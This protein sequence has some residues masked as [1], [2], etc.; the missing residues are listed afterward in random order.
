MLCFNHIIFLTVH[1]TS[2]ELHVAEI[3]RLTGSEAHLVVTAQVLFVRQN[4][5]GID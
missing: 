5:G 1:I 2:G 4:G 3:G